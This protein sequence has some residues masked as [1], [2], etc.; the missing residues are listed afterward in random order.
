MGRAPALRFE[1]AFPLHNRFLRRLLPA[2]VALAAMSSGVPAQTLER[3]AA[4]KTV[5][6]G[7]VA[8][9]APFASTSSDGVP[10][11]YAIDLCAAVVRAIGRRFEGVT[12]RYVNTTMTDAFKAIA[13]GRID[14]LC[15]AITATLERRES[16]D[17]SEPI[18]LTGMSAL[19]H[20]H[21]QHYLRELF[22]GAH[23]ISPPRSLE[24]APFETLRIG[25]RIGTSTEAVLRQAVASGGY[26]A[27]IVGFAGHADGLAALEAREIDAY[28]ADRGLLI[29]LFAKARDPA[30]LELGTRLFTREPYAIAM[31]RG[32]D[33]LRLLVDRALTEFYGTPEFSALLSRYFG[34]EAPQIG[35][36]VIALSIPE[37]ET[38]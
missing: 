13:N 9:Q 38:P 28:F 5:Q 8:D 2:A 15:G 32:D 35:A 20:A 36:Q 7:F 25:V 11:G 18:F 23:E 21:P 10:T 6:I 16:V 29:A 3:I 33:D 24:M 34:H 26:R 17:F 4:T 19:M 14:L 27:E 12:A 1:W 22:L 30:A 37:I 31:Q